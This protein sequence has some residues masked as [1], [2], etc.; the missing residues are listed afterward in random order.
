MGGRVCEHSR[1]GLLGFCGGGRAGPPPP[2]HTAGMYD[3]APM[4]LRLSDTEASANCYKVRLL[5]S[6][7]E[8]PYERVPVDIFAGGTMSAEYAARNPSL[9]TP[10]L[11]LEPGKFL[12]E[13]AAIM[14]HLAEGTHLLP[15]DRDERAQVY[16][17]LFF[18]QSAVLPTIAMLRFRLLTRRASLDDPAEAPSLNMS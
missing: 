11:E 16:R 14:L 4:G 7:L 3:P 12:P 15:E 10:V 2:S 17:W 18:E 5:L 9:T 1:Q 13:S 6:H 8:L